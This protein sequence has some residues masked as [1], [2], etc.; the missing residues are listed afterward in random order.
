MYALRGGRIMRKKSISILFILTC[1]ACI[2]CACDVYEIPVRKT[3][4][5]T[6]CN[7]NI[8]TVEVY[9]YA[10]KGF[11]LVESEEEKMI[12]A[13]ESSPYYLGQYVVK[14]T[15][16]ETDRR[17]EGNTGYWFDFGNYNVG[18]LVKDGDYYTSYSHESAFYSGNGDGKGIMLWAK[19]FLTSDETDLDETGRLDVFRQGEFYPV[20]YGWDELRSIFRNYDIDESAYTINSSAVDMNLKEGIVTLKYYEDKESVCFEVR[21]P[22]DKSEGTE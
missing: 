20:A 12:A 17:G 2:A 4:T 14:Y 21:M 6:V 9:E 19:S 11:R 10:N 1:I 3:Y 18:Y 16:D 22:D 7:E 5:V 13:I 15:Q 8:C